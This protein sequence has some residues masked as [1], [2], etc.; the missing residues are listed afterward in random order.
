MAKL[1]SHG[2]REARAYGSWRAPEAEPLVRGV[3]LLT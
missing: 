1:L 2:E 3:W